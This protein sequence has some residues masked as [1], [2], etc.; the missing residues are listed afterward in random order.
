MFTGCWFH[1]KIRPLSVLENKPNTY[2]LSFIKIPKWEL[3]LLCKTY[4]PFRWLCNILFSLFISNNSFSCSGATFGWD[5]IT[6]RQLSKLSFFP[7]GVLVFHPR[8]LNTDPNNPDPPVGEIEL[9][10][11]V[12]LS[13]QSPACMLQ[14]AQAVT[15]LAKGSESHSLLQGICFPNDYFCANK[16]FLPLPFTPECLFHSP[17]FTPLRVIHCDPFALWNLDWHFFILRSYFRG[18]IKTVTST[19]VVSKNTYFC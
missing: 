19:E 18:F 16:Q 13:T 4:C 5:N 14:F 9:L 1:L 12:F 10:L 2:E 15:G 17:N 6:V 8:R 7:T 11:S 3:E